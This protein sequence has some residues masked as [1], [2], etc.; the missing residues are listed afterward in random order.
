MTISQGVERGAP[1]WHAYSM[2]SDIIV[3]DREELIFL[4]CEAAE[5]EH[6]VMCTYLYAMWSLKR[7]ES[8]GVT[9]DELAAIER[10]RASLAPG[11]ARGDAASLPRQQPAFALGSA[12]HLWKPEFPVRPG[13]FPADVIMRLSPF[14]ERALD[15]FLYIE[16]PEGLNLSDGKGFDHKDHYERAARP[17]C[18]RPRRRTTPARATSITAR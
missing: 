14:S 4:L 8:E 11:R 3:Q 12:P 9:P 7:D 15:H 1:L 2:S 5:F 6:A 13:H 16:R 10:W 18:S 17:I